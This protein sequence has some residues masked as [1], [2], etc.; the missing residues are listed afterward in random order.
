M[1]ETIHV[2]IDNSETSSDHV[3]EFI[4]VMVIDDTSKSLEKS[5][6]SFSVKPQV[7]PELTFEY[8]SLETSVEIIRETSKMDCFTH[9]NRIEGLVQN[10]HNDSY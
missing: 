1:I 7:S 8:F 3:H 2:H 6:K 5:L 4:V 9:L 10:I